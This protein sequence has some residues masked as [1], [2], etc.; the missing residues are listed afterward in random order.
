MER[1][2]P[3]L[4]PLYEDTKPISD[5]ASLSVI[6]VDNIK[7]SGK[8]QTPKTKEK[9]DA[10]D[11]IG[12]TKDFKNLRRSVTN[13]E[14]EINSDK[15][16]SDVQTITPVRSFMLRKFSKP[17]DTYPES[18]VSSPKPKKD[19][20]LD[21]DNQKDC[22]DS[23]K[24][25]VIKLPPQKIKAKDASPARKHSPDASL[26]TTRSIKM[27]ESN[28][29]DISG[30]ST[31][32]TKAAD[33][34]SKDDNLYNEDKPAVIK[35]PTSAKVAPKDLPA[36]RSKVSVS[37]QRTPSV[38]KLNTSPSKVK[39]TDDSGGNKTPSV[40]RLRTPT[41]RNSETLPP[42]PKSPTLS[43]EGLIHPDSK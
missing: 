29:G 38:F 15:I 36:T 1:A 40:F 8:S 3:K 19:K 9:V 25:A 30:R 5:F 14:K 32:S 37:P 34:T 2:E 10:Q 17:Q 22:K 13:T 20:A 35:L 26:R 11:S 24:P 23:D 41:K 31:R 42:L 4:E 43:P 18:S 27:A 12:E 21:S 28:K 39:H 16:K 7:F 6:D 33:A